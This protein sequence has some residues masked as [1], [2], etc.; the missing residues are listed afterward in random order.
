MFVLGYDVGSS[1]IKATLLDIDTGKPVA[2]ATS[3][4]RE[5]EI[6]AEK[7]G[8]AEQHPETW[9]EHV[10]NT[11]AMILRDSNVDASDIKAVGISYQMHG[12]VIVDKDHTVLRPSIIWCDSRAVEI[13]DKAFQAIGGETCLSHLLNS[14]GNFTASKLRWVQE[15]EPQIY[16]KIHKAMLPGDYIAMKMTGEIKTTPS[17]LSEGILWD[18]DSHE[19]ADIV[20]DHYGISRDL[21]PDTAPTFSIQGEMTSQAAVE[22]G[23]SAGTP[24][25]YRAGD[26]PNNALSLNVLNPGE[27]AATAGTSGVVYAVTD[28][29]AYDPQSRVNPFV[30]V[31]YG[32]DSPRYGILLCVNGTGI[33]NSWLRH[34][35]MGAGDYAGMNDLAQQAPPGA[36][37]LVIL[38][39]GN[40]AERTLGNR[41]IGAHFHNI[42][43]NTHKREHYLRAAQEGI[44]FALNYGLEITR[45]MGV[46]ISK[47]RAGCANMF[48]SPLFR[49]VFAATTGTAVELYETDGSQGA[50]RGAGIGTGLYS[51]PAEAF[52]GLESTNTIEPE[53]SSVER[54]QD[55]YGNWKNILHSHIKE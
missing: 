20:L 30:H 25:S 52:T 5:L 47:V 40:G 19:L 16:A 34:Q 29:E 6:I 4:D 1:S 55:I 45:D 37:G 26:Q 22:L 10:K 3:P 11:S 32:P 53:P 21:I 7:P 42:Q 39:Y 50:A 49:E 17:G 46:D 13:G 41:D 31:N 35:V 54:Y 33:L 15:N 8:W 44:V 2:S 23:L 36:E 14:P 24:I 51:A 18:F 28:R 38:P 27:I 43:F 48:L 9:W 12:L